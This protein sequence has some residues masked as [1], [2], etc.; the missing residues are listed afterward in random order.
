MTGPIAVLRRLDLGALL[1]AV[2]ALHGVVDPNAAWFCLAR[3]ARRRPFRRIV[4]CPR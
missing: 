2:A 4:R 1:F 3:P